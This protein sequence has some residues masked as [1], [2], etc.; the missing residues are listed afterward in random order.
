MVAGIDVMARK[1]MSSA[2]RRVTAQKCPRVTRQLRLN[3]AIGL[4]PSRT[5]IMGAKLNLTSMN[6]VGR[7]RTVAANA[8][9]IPTGD[10][11]WA[12]GT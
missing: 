3:E 4:R 2:R 12:P 10:S 1:T 9:R 6:R 8:M 11:A 7:A 5:T